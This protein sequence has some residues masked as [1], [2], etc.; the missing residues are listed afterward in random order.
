MLMVGGIIAAIVHG[1][2]MPIM[3]IVFGA[4]TDLF[5]DTNKLANI[6]ELY[7]PNITSI[8]PNATTEIIID[9][10]DAIM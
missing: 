8:F 3:T 10:I 9:N 4:M 1:M 7:M 2:A 6:L 5:V